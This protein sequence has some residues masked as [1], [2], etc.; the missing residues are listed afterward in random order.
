MKQV[1]D[2]MAQHHVIS[3]TRIIH[4]LQHLHEGP[5]S[6]LTAQNAAIN[7]IRQ[8]PSHLAVP[9]VSLALKRANNLLL[10][11]LNL[12]LNLRIR[13][14]FRLFFIVLGNILAFR[15]FSFRDGAWLFFFGSFFNDLL[16]GFNIALFL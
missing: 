7:R 6:E 10:D 15:L 2:L 8:I 1:L 12:L 9:N 16:F 3:A 5:Q 4:V 14:L 13:C 11:T